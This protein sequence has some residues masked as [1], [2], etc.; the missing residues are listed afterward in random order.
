MLNIGKLGRGQEDYYLEAVADS[1]ED[2]YFGSGEAPGYWLG[3]ALPVRGHVSADALKNALSGFDPR[4]GRPLKQRN[5]PQR[6]PGFDLT[7]RAPKSVSLLHA[8]AD[9][10]ITKEMTEAHDAAVGAALGYLERNAC[11]TRR[12]NRASDIEIHSGSGFIAAAFRHRTSRAGDPL[13]HTH[14]L[15]AN[16]TQTKA[17]KWGALDARQIYAHAKTAGY[18]YQAHLRME[19]TKRLGVAWNE[20]AKGTADI[21]GVP[22]E[23]VKAFSKRRV[24]IEGRMK[25]RGEAGATAAQVAALDTRHAKNYNVTAERLAPAWREKA[26]GLGLTPEAIDA[27]YQ[28]A[29][30]RRVTFDSSRRLLSELIGPEGL[31]EASSSFGRRDVLQQLSERL[32][33]A[34]V[35]DIERFADRLLASELVV[36][37]AARSDGLES[38]EIIRRAD[39]RIVVATKNELRYSTPEML[40]TERRVIERALDRQGSQV[41]MVKPATAERA[42]ARRP[43][44]SAEQRR[45]VRSLVTSGDGVQVVVGRA[46]TGK[47]FA[48]DAAREAWQ[49]EGYRVIG[50]ALAARAA[51][52][53]EGG[54]GIESYTID[55]LLHDLDHPRFG[56]LSPTTVV[57]VDEAGM[58]GTRKLDQLLNHV[59][60]GDSKLVLVGD[61]RQLPEIAAGGA[62][63]GI[64]NRSGAIHLTE[65]KRQDAAWER[66]A[67]DSLRHGKAE[68]AI[69]DYKRQ[70]RVMVGETAEEA[71]VT[72]ITDWWKAQSE[73]LDTVLVAARKDD[74]DDLNQRAR[75]LLKDSGNVKDDLLRIGDKTFAL[76]DRVMAL[77]NSKGLGLINGMRGWIVAIDAKKLEISMQNDNGQE[78]TLP[79][80]YLEAGHIT[81]A[82]AVTGHKSQ[83]MTVDAAFVLGDETMYREWG[84]VAMSRG[85]QENRLY[86]V[87]LLNLAREETGGA[88]DPKVDPIENIIRGLT[89]SRA[90]QLA[91]EEAELSRIRSADT[92]ALLADRKEI[93]S[94]FLSR[95]PDPHEDLTRLQAE[96]QRLKS[97]IDQ[98]RTKEQAARSQLDEMSR[99]ARA[100]RG[101]EVKRLNDRMRRADSSQAR[102]KE[103]LHLVIEERSHLK[104]RARQLDSWYHQNADAFAR[105]REVVKELD[106][107]DVSKVAALRV[108][109][110]KYILDVLGEEPNTPTA[111]AGWQNIVR[112]IED[113]RTRWKIRDPVRALGGS[114]RS[115]TQF[116]EREGIERSL[117]STLEGVREI[118]RGA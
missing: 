46:G 10:S 112:K 102:L 65:V 72:M 108:A 47:T 78:I 58:A 96:E 67:L 52:E 5:S 26:E 18:L 69:E 80:K 4:D 81:H 101:A 37:L 105:Y 74:V 42:L 25:D 30:Y 107:R 113:Y 57:V 31:T 64:K 110:P 28:R 2:Y 15:V 91:I 43:S 60:A 92:P 117:K 95:P 54:A 109:T 33:L 55:S 87:A 66:K 16:L 68:E 14:V 104:E 7:F 45:M 56:G 71:R 50:C 63:R 84:Y 34:S 90:K 106:R 6:V 51:R 19:L 76:G 62:F 99:V 59:V 85:R 38:S 23:V 70:G 20:V 8:L 100:R 89:R 73:G 24:E 93:E 35:T 29:E 82:Y 103:A 118:E 27:L 75:A 9:R 116:G 44:L 39:G 12:R 79:R 36:S 11:A 86:V 40:E 3:S 114:P 41:A 21:H 94:L 77:R 88:Q 53:L 17:G 32:G 22:R 1:G 13:L 115:T 83:G 61:D 48:L 111:R 97:L 49:N 98:E